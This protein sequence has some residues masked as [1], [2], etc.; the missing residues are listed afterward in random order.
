V[1]AFGGGFVDH[2]KLKPNGLDAQPILLGDGLVDDRAD[3]LTVHKAVHDLDRARDVGE[4]VISPLAQGIFTAKIDWDDAH[5]EPVAQIL[6]DAVR[7]APGV[8]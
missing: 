3:P 1:R 7:G 8:G 6:P 2:A 5:A 4:P